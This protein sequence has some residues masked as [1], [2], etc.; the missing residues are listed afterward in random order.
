MKITIRGVRGS[1]PTCSPNTVYYGGNTS[2]TEVTEDGWTLVMD[3]GSGIRHLN[4]SSK[5][6]NRRID[7]LLTHLHLDHIIGLGFFNYLF[8]PEMVDYQVEQVPVSTPLSSSY[9]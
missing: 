7:I 4:N 3:G 5:P 8:D 6:Q 9:R 1:I 2:C